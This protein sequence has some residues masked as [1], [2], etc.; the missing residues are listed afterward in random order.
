[1]IVDYTTEAQAI[2][3]GTFDAC[4]VGSGP[5]GISLARKLA[6]SGLS[7]ALM[8]GGGLDFDQRS[9]DLYAG[10]C[11]GR[12]YYPLDSTRLRYFGGTSGHWGGLCRPLE[13]WDFASK[14]YLARSGW[15]I[16]RAELDPFAAEADK[17]VS[18]PSADTYPD[19]TDV[20]AGEDFRVVRF[21]HSS[22]TRFGDAYREEIRSSS[23]ITLVVNANLVDLELDETLATVTGARFRSYEPGAPGGLVRAQVYCLCMGG[24][25]NP[26]FLLNATR[27]V[28]HGI[29][30]E[31]DLVGRG[32]CEHPA[33][34]IG[35]VLFEGPIPTSREYQP[36][37]ELMA[38][39]KV[40]N[41]HLLLGTKARSFVKEFTRSAVCTTEFTAK[42]ARSVLGMELNCDAG[43]MSAYLSLRQKDASMGNL[44]LIVEQSINPDSRVML[45]EERDQFGLRRIALDWQYSEVDLR[46]MRT[47]AMSI[48]ERFAETG[49]GR[50]QLKD[51]LLAPEIDPPQ[52]GTGNGEVGLHH[53]MCT[54]RMSADPTQGVV[55]PNCRVHSVSNL[56]IGGA[57]VF[58]SAGY[59][60]PTYTI[61]ELALR[62]GDHLAKSLAA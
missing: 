32:F 39:E 1:M 2:A 20:L 50:V 62:L 6:A 48:A 42:L 43:G 30:N 44:G 22:P 8:E 21:R 46:T 27:Q 34:S 10:T 23:R 38:R 37:P 12:D 18:I 47:G 7:V 52:L 35:K 28:P 57:S 61:V 59:A 25:E 19:S 60:N 58:A 26:R 4:V 41:F 13:P 56:Y 45:S 31:H 36:T 5:A 53:H 17:I 16:E 24:L 51:W 3:Q 29:G 33:Y 15:P 14:P 55:D 9:Q 40:A 49:A 54:T 11:I